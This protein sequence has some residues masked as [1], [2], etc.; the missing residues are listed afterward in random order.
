MMP[1]R[2]YVA[3]TVAGKWLVCDRTKLK[4]IDDEVAC[5]DSRKQARAKARE[6]NY[7]KNKKC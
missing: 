1:T 6:L 3:R 7:E 5:F 4:L 2:F